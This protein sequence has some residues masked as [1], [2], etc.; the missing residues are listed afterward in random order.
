MPPHP[1]QDNVLNLYINKR[2][3]TFGKWGSGFDNKVGSTS[4][5]DSAS[6]RRGDTLSGKLTSNL[7]EKRRRGTTAASIEH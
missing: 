2:T 3:R 6:V 4:T 7:I 5:Q 1:K